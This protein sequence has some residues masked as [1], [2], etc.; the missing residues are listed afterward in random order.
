MF[1]RISFLGVRGSWPQ[2]G[3]DFLV[4]G[5]TICTA[6]EIDEQYFIF[7]AGTGLSGF[8]SVIREKNLKKASLFISHYHIDHVIGLTLLPQLFE[9][10][11]DNFKIDLYA[12]RLDHFHPEIIFERLIQPPL[13]P[14]TLNHLR[15]N[16]VFK[17]F[18]VG[19]TLNIDGMRIDTIALHHPGTS[20]GYK[21]KH[22]KKQL[23]Y[24]TDVGPLNQE[25]PYPESLHHFIYE[26]DLLIHDTSFTPEE[27]P[28]YLHYGHYS[29]DRVCLAAE[30]AQ[31]KKLA[32][33]HHN[34]L[35]TDQKLREIEKKAKNMFE[36]SFLAE[37]GQS[38]T[39]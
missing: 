38:L 24:I 39:I 22:G 29:Y 23:C 1:M 6:V 18:D 37:E 3:K 16:L 25:S 17:P 2:S 21:V 32:L 9:E 19:D 27:L 4:G 8:S 10:K 35:Y 33:Y 5:H 36:G 14:F 7:D 34:P 12:P 31:V 26:S 15:Q 28:D 20:C 30:R 13:Y 11:T